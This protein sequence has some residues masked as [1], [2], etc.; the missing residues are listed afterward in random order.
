[1]LKKRERRGT[2][3]EREQERE[4]VERKVNKSTGRDQE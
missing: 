1:M 2:E 4:G 3:R